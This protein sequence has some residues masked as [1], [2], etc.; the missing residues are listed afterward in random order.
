MV[1]AEGILIFTFSWFNK[2]HAILLE[3]VFLD[4]RLVRGKSCH[5][6]RVGR[7]VILDRDQSCQCRP[8]R[9]RER[10]DCYPYGAS[11]SA[12]STVVPFPLVLLSECN[13]NSVCEHTSLTAIRVAMVKRISCFHLTTEP[14]THPKYI[15]ILFYSVLKFVVLLFDFNV[16]ISCGTLYMQSKYL[17]RD[18]FHF[19]KL[20]TRSTIFSEFP[21]I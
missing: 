4:S 12:S 5:F 17:P 14:S 3:S 18:F 9:I 8:F 20:S 15:I 21:G 6:C 10:D 7:E 16:D 13:A 19:F 11:Y 1:S 2:R